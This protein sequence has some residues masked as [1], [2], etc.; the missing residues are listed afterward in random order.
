[1][2]N[3]IDKYGQFPADGKSLRKDK[4]VVVVSEPQRLKLLHGQK[5]GV[6]CQVAVS[7]DYIH[8]GIVTIPPRV[9][10]EVDSIGGDS[11]F[12]PLDGVVSFTIEDSAD[13]PKAVSRERFV[14][15]PQEKFFLPANTRFRMHNFSSEKVDVIFI[16]AASPGKG[17][18][19]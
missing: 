16:A 12:V 2:T 17:S 10:S 3:N 6:L 5:A 18:K 1:M 14:V 9:H 15:K 13:N 7:N 19:R 8:E 4:T 11:V